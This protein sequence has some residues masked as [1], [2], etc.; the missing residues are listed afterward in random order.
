MAAVEKIMTAEQLFNAPDMGRCELLRGEL[1]M[2]SPSGS[3]T[4]AIREG[5]E[6]NT[7]ALMITELTC[8]I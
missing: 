3:R 6:S 7:V 4:E 5:R 1:V 8:L 2:M